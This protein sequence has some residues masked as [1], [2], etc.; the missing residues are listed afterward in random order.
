MPALAAYEH[1][2]AVMQFLWLLMIV[3]RLLVL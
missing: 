2:G 1:V 3:L